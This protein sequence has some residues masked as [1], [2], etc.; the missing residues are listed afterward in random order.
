MLASVFSRSPGKAEPARAL[1]HVIVIRATSAWSLSVLNNSMKVA[2]SQIVATALFPNPLDKLLS[3]GPGA[4]P[5]GRLAWPRLFARERE[6]GQAR[7]RVDG[8]SSALSPGRGVLLE[9]ARKSDALLGCPAPRRGRPGPFFPFGSHSCI[10]M[11]FSSPQKS[12]PLLESQIKENQQSITEQL[13][14]YG[15]DIPE[16]ETEKMFFLIDVSSAVASR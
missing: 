3:Q 16:E 13:Q 10:P 2:K 6:G 9:E 12:L 4:M 1:H 8:R 11:T 14:K 7:G 15:M 5:R